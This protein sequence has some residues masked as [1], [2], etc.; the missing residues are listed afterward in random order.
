MTRSTL[1]VPLLLL[2]APAGAEPNP[3]RDVF[4]GETHLH[5][6]W[7]LD[8]YAFG[9]HVAGPEQAYRYAKGEEP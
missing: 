7:S 1:L 6:S 4:F 3:Q 5:T 2:A 8:A 9:N